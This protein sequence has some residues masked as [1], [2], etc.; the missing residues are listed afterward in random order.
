MA[1]DKQARRDYISKEH[2]ERAMLLPP[3]GVSLMAVYDHASAALR[4][5]DDLRRS[6]FTPSGLSLAVPISEETGAALDSAPAGQPR[7]EALARVGREKLGP[8]ADWLGTSL[9]TMRVP[10][11]G[12]ILAVTAQGAATM[13]TSEGATAGGADGALAVLGVPPGHAER[14]VADLKAGRV[15]LGAY[16]TEQGMIERATTILRRNRPQ[17]LDTY[18][19]PAQTD[20]TAALRIFTS[21][22]VVGA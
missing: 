10:G 14:Y 4:A 22:H 20:I 13:G 16:Q 7:T 19:V 2:P 8:I 17:R 3:A 21:P 11:A 9:R 18:E 5:V 12:P 1:W 6:R 15:L